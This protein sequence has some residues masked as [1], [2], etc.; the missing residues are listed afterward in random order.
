[1]TQNKPG[2][3]KPLYLETIYLPVSCR[4]ARRLS[5]FHVPRPNFSDYEARPPR[6]KARQ[7]LFLILNNFLSVFYNVFLKKWRSNGYFWKKKHLLKMWTKTF[8]R[9]ATLCCASRPYFTRQEKCWKKVPKF[10]FT[11]SD[12]QCKIDIFF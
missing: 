7:T 4:I 12:F 3:K 9:L 6:L 1:M 10:L 8:L 2:N 5:D 11:K